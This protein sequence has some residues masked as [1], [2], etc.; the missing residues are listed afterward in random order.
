[1]I[2]DF[3]PDALIFDIDGV[4]LNVEK[5]FP[6]V[7]RTAVREC[8]SSLCGG[9]YDFGGYSAEHERI[10]KRHGAFN[11]DYDIAWVLLSMAAAGGESKLSEAFPSPDKLSS[12]LESYSGNV[13]EWCVSRYGSFVSRSCVREY[14]R[15]LYFGTS[16]RKGL[17]L[18]EYPMLTS[19]WHELPLPVG[20]YTGRDLPEWNL[21]KAALGWEDFP[22]DLIIH[23]DM[24]IT[25]PSPL[26]LEMLCE[27]LGVSSP[28]F[29]G[30]TGADMKT[31]IAFGRGGFAAIGGLLPEAKYIFKTPDEALKTLFGYEKN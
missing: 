28:L 20:I 15:S 27:R 31:Q 7:I 10:L 16:S 26:G 4:L 1:M 29:F 11:D 17:H 23:L 30:D 3:T 6:E 5:S 12:E 19:G 22:D 2:L 9:V 21:A 13:P 25:K 18:L 14:C 24:G 8:W